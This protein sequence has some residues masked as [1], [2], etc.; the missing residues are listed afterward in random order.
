MWR[1]GAT[2]LRTG[3]DDFFVDRRNANGFPPWCL[4]RSAS[5]DRGAQLGGSR[6][7]SP[8]VEASLSALRGVPMGSSKER[9][10]RIDESHSENR[11][12]PPGGSSDGAGRIARSPSAD[13]RVVTTRSSHPARRRAASR[14]ADRIV[15]PGVD[16]TS[17]RG[18]MESFE[19]IRATP[20][21]GS[22]DRPRQAPSSSSTILGAVAERSRSPHPC[23]MASPS[24]PSCVLR[25]PSCRAPRGRRSSRS[26]DRSTPLCGSF[27][28][29]I[30]GVRSWDPRNAVVR[31]EECDL[32]IRRR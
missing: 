19:A 6:D 28:R 21:G 27:G 31:S 16:G 12:V 22:V 2:H 20:I 14:C 7:S 5:R 11:G 26:I 8:R 30:R 29:A 24:V 17:L 10:R 23:S 1:R 15:R 25:T 3:A 4:P 13:L 18:G 32:G 9:S